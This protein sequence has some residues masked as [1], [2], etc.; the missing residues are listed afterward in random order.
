MRPWFARCS[1][2]R[3]YADDVTTPRRVL[4]LSGPNLNLLGSREPSIY[5]TSSLQEVVDLAAREAATVGL[6]VEH[7]QTNRASELVNGSSNPIMMRS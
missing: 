2:S 4:L 1:P 7:R 5:G 6:T 3:K